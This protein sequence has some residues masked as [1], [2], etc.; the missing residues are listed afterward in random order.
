M[1]VGKLIR[2]PKDSDSAAL[3]G[4]RA[5]MQQTLDRIREQA[6]KDAN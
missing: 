4:Y 3:D 2:V 1:R 6:E 5:E